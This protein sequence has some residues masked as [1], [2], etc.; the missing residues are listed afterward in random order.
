MTA[1]RLTFIATA[2]GPSAFTEPGTDEDL[3]TYYYRRVFLSTIRRHFPQILTTLAE[4]WR[5]AWDERE[6]EAAVRDWAQEWQLT[7]PWLLAVAHST[8]QNWLARGTTL[9]ESWVLECYPDT[10]ADLPVWT[11][12]TGVFSVPRDSE[13]PAPMQ[14]ELA[15][16]GI[17]DTDPA[18]VFHHRS[19]YPLAEE[20][21]S[22]DEPGTYRSVML[23]AFKRYLDEHIRER[24]EAAEE[25]GAVAR[26]KIR[27]PWLT[28]GDAK[29]DKTL[30]RDFSWLIRF[31]CLA[32]KQVDLANEAGRLRNYVSRRI[33]LVRKRIG[34][35]AS[36]RD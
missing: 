1:H 34:L 26:K 27:S 23:V 15:R 14:A 33:G 10:P 11:L 32:E 35:P 28:F 24:S 25:A 7:E 20:P 31:H 29:T 2:G 36:G 21:G 3:T 12:P 30:R 6:R 18:A 13:D 9:P 8:V 22:F 16:F 5:P 4:R 19:Y 17:W